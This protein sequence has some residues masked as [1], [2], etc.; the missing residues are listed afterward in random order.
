[1]KL[2]KPTIIGFK[3]V[4]AGLLAFTISV[5]IISRFI[6]YSSS[7]A[8]GV[9]VSVM[10]AMVMSASKEAYRVGKKIS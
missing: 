1:M 9:G 5:L 2:E 3:Y 8:V 4:G 6:E 7:C 10:S